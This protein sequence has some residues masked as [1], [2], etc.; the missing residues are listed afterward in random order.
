[1]LVQRN[2]CK[3][4]VIGSKVYCFGGK[5]SKN[6][7]LNSGEVFCRKLKTWNYITSHHKF[8]TYFICV[9]PFMNKIYLFGDFNFNNWVYDPIKH[10]WEKYQ[11]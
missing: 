10:S 8:D 9:C 5:D 11:L 1:M 7:D 4:A 2:D 3:T 6:R